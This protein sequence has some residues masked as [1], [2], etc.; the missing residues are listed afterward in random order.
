MPP[1]RNRDTYSNQDKEPKSL[2]GSAIKTVFSFVLAVFV[3]GIALYGY[4]FVILNKPPTNFPVNIPVAIPEGTSAKEATAIFAKAG[5]VRSE[6]VLYLSL[7]LWYEPSDIKASTYVF[8]EPI[9]TKTIANELTLGNFA[10]DLLRITHKEGERA[11]T[12]AVNADKILTQ[13]DANEFIALA[14]PFEGKLFPDTYYIPKDFT[15]EE[16]FNLLL[17]TYNERVHIPY[18]EQ[19]LTQREL[20]EDQ[21]LILAS[22][23]ERE[24]NSPESM[25]MVSGILQN[26]LD[27][28]MALQTDASIEYVLNKPLGELLPEDLEIDTPYNTYLYPGLPPTPIGNPGLDAIRAVLEPTPSE[29]LFYITGKDGSFYYAKNFDEHRLNIARYL[30]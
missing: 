20:T 2:I 11:T 22:I 4:L 27:I 24:A 8:S 30:R 28:D 5:L 23:I 7:I 17:D 13:F 25:K 15:A 21:M 9:D 10:T 19:T 12:L 16:L 29:Y 3:L 18:Y 6:L 1:L 26:R 14:E